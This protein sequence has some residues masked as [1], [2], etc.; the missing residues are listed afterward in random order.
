MKLFYK[1]APLC[2][3]ILLLANFT[4]AQSTRENGIKLYQAG[5]YKE[6]VAA[7]EK[8]SKKDKKDAEIW[9]YLG[10]A[11]IQIKDYKKAVKAF[12]KA[13]DIK[14]ESA[15]FWTNQAYAYLLGGD[16]IEA[17]R[18]SDKAIKLD[19]NNA[20]AYFI[21]SIA[22]FRDNKIEKAME[23]VDKAIA[24]NPDYAAAYNHKAD[25]ILA[26]FGDGTEKSE[27]VIDI[28]LLKQAKAVLEFC[29]KNCANNAQKQAQQKRIEG[30]SA[31]YEYFKENG[32]ADLKMISNED[33][34]IVNPNAGDED[35]KPA[36]ITDMPRMIIDRSPWQFV[37]T[38]KPLT[39]VITF[40]IRVAALFDAKGWVSHA[41][42]VKGDS[43]E[44]N[45]N[46]N[47]IVAALKIKFQPATKNGKPFSQVVIVE[48]K[49]QSGGLGYIQ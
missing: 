2:V 4:F 3:V 30:L 12:D 7:L 9:N 5:K 39:R 34:N 23:E 42:V 19:A 48:Y 1:I 43:S 46:D 29:V 21:H 20:V 28:D 11:F 24:L 14:P 32:S 8:A 41:L 10:L 37:K 45:F 15:S 40:K 38:S 35:I 16:L 47:A 25:V 17:R 22:N 6:A 31:F 27:P 49:G 36:V 33:R 18:N 26:R 13:V 44:L